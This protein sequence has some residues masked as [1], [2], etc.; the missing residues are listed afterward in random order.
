MILFNNN[1]PLAVSTIL[2]YSLN[3]ANI[4]FSAVYSESLF[5]ML[6]FSSIYC[7]YTNKFLLA[8]VL[9]FSSCL[10]RSNGILNFGY[11]AYYCLKEHL[12]SI[13]ITQQFISSEKTS[14]FKY[15]RFFCF[16]TLNLGFIK[17]FLLILKLIVSFAS[18]YSAFFLYQYYIYSKFCKLTQSEKRNIYIPNELIKYGQE[19]SYHLINNETNP[20]W[21]S[22][23]LP[24]SY[25]HV[26]AN[27]WKVGFLTYWQFKQIPNFLLASPVLYLVIRSVKRFLSSFSSKN[28]FNLFGLVNLN[29]EHKFYS[30]FDKNKNLFPFSIHLLALF[31]SALFFMHVQVS[32]LQ[33][34]ILFLNEYV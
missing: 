30:R 22:L 8:V 25:T 32:L 18:A 3:P 6:T 5:S 20:N 34:L 14:F 10:C 19:N 9:V 21:C 4:F 2:L 31:V 1:N 17:N 15:V 11:I 13:K 26:Q 7:L 27:Y 16:K 29:D 12:S 28:L 33:L 23:A 24:F